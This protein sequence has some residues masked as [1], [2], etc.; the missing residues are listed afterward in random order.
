VS[1]TVNCGVFL[2][3]LPLKVATVTV[4]LAVT[5]LV[6]VAVAVTV[7]V[8]VGTAAGVTFAAG[9]SCPVASRIP[10]NAT[11]AA[12]TPRPITVFGC[13]RNQGLR[14]PGPEEGG[15]GLY[16]GMGAAASVVLPG[17]RGIDDT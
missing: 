13:C 14:G 7:F 6:A 5:V 1:V 10:P 15:C 2:I 11:R 9:L 17:G 4:A 3:P 8:T 12:N 16:G